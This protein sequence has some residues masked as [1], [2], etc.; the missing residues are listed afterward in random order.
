M[1][2][3]ARLS[4]VTLGA[5]DLGRSVAFYERLGWRQ[6]ASS[7]PGVIAWFDLGGAYLGL[8]P[9]HELAAD[10]GIA[11]PGPATE[12]SGVTLAMNVESDAEV[13]RVMAEAEAAGA[14][15]LKPPVMAIFDGLSAYF[16]DP[17][18]HAWEVAHNPQFPLHESGRITIP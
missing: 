15:V 13:R 8:F 1:T 11:D 17:D 16:A 10:A 14:T 5:A 12:F 2:V 7:V 18:G 3:P 9:R 6:R 4:I